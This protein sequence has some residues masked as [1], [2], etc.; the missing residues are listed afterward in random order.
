MK[1][2]LSMPKVWLNY[3]NL[4][5]K[6]DL[7]LFNNPFVNLILKHQKEVNIRMIMESKETIEMLKYKNPMIEQNKN[8]MNVLIQKK[9]H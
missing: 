3:K 2:H 1:E 9:V 4:S 7:E 6:E 8:H 5:I